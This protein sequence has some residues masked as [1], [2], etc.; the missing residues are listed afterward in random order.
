MSFTGG[1]ARAGRLFTRA[2]AFSSEIEKGN[3]LNIVTKSQLAEKMNAYLKPIMHSIN[4]SECQA[5]EVA[6][7]LGLLEGDDCRVQTDM[8][9]LHRLQNMLRGV[10]RL[11]VSNADGIDQT[12]TEL[13]RLLRF[14]RID[15]R[16]GLQF[17]ETELVDLLNDL[18]YINEA[19]ML[20]NYFQTGEE[21]RAT[22]RILAQRLEEGRPE[23]EEV[24]LEA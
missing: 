2:T 22:I 18:G 19:A 9:R 10:T 1:A 16:N 5:R 21:D 20:W 17:G 12:F 14:D 6:E 3:F 4:E 23:A 13:E 8:E 24:A 11:A 7:L 15:K